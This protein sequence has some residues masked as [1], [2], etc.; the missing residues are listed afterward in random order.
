MK[1]LLDVTKIGNM[2]MKNR[3]VRAAVA[4]KTID[5]SISSDVV[6]LY[7]ALARGGVGTVVT[8]YTLVDG[9]EKI[10]SIVA[11]YKEEFLDGHRR[12]VDAVHEHGVNVILQL[13]Y[14][15]SYTAPKDV[16][17]VVTLAPSAVANLITRTL[18]REAGVDELRAIQQKFAQ[19]ALFAI[20]AGYDGV[21][22]HA[23]HGFLLSQ[24]MTPYYNRRTDLYGGS[25]ENRS[26]MTLETYD[27]V[28]GAVGKDFPIWVKI[29]STDG[30]DEGLTPEDCL[31]LCK[32][33]TEHGVDAIEVSGKWFTMPVE[34]HAYFA[35]AAKRVAK[36]NQVAVILTGGNRDF[37]EMT[38]LLNDSEIGYFGI[39]R[40]FMNEPNLIDR[41]RKEMK[42]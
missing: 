38:R 37:K 11:S 36:E 10:L 41:F 28:R 29:N 7:R 15:G 1:T 22:I 4:D 16:S 9:S 2:P 26:R 13:V 24:F 39:A 5:G 6:D 31:H 20:E 19:A 27:A 34:A 25:V 21:E 35:D 3:F 18:A 8:G 33:L 14:V 17:G 12:L 23:A 40:P 32:K 42:T 30:I